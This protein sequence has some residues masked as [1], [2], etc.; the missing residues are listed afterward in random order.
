MATKEAVCKI[1]NETY[2]GQ[3]G[4][5]SGRVVDHCVYRKFWHCLECDETGGTKKFSQVHRGHAYEVVGG[6][7]RTF[8]GNY[9]K[10]K[11]LTQVRVVKPYEFPVWMPT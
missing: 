1:C 11:Q 7:Q 6:Y 2:T 10:V 8:P 5:K 4:K 3:V 9:Y